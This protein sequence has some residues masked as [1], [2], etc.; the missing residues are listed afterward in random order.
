M[1]VCRKKFGASS[2][3]EVKKKSRLNFLHPENVRLHMLILHTL[4][5]IKVDAWYTLYQASKYAQFY[6]NMQNK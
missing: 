2:V 5:E 1:R 4:Y 3:H 6:I